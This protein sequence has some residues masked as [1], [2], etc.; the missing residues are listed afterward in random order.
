M[1]QL[2][3]AVLP[4][5][6]D[7]Q[8]LEANLPPLLRELEAWNAEV[9]VV[10]DTGTGVLSAWLADRFSDLPAGRLRV[11][12]RD[13]NGGFGP[14][15][16]NGARLARGEYLLALNP[17]VRV[18]PGFLAPLLDA[19][20]DPEVFAASP[21]VLLNG[22]PSRPESHNALLMD[23]GHLRVVAREDSGR[24]DPVPIPF[25]IGGALLM[26]RSEFLAGGGFDPLFAPFYWED[27]DLCLSAWRTGRRVVEIPLSVVEHHHRG[28]IG[29]AV[30]KQVVLAAIEKNR[31]LLLWKHL[32]DADV[33]RDHVTAIW[34]DA[35]DASMAG[36]R[37]EL[38]WLALALQELPRVTESRAE[39]GARPV[40]L[41]AALRRSDPA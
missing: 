8:L 9:V 41:E 10:D 11:I 2:I 12:S 28:T 19:L 34:R 24:S 7:T 21:R 30:P 25:A 4:S 22:E 13:E 14:A 38:V 23:D 27:V 35:L 1:T 39:L 16:L 29:G 37:E 20:G 17:D 40:T 26:R 3:S 5:L 15:L 18:R 33:A 32:D 36:R 31:H 6:A